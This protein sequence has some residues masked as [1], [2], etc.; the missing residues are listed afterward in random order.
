MG[1]IEEKKES[2]GTWRLC[3]FSLNLGVIDLDIYIYTELVLFNALVYGSFI[4]AQGLDG[5]MHCFIVFIYI[6][7]LVAIHTIWTFAEICE[8][9]R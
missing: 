7:V 2:S 8:K 9:L 5:L 3:I 6:V 4:T 1:L